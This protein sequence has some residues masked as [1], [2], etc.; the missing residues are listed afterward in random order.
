MVKRKSG[1]R[2][3]MAR[4]LR[5]PKYRPQTVELRNKNSKN[6]RKA[7]HKGRPCDQHLP[8]AA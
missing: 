1:S 8:L 4:E 5:T 7:K 6:G 3:L 2:D